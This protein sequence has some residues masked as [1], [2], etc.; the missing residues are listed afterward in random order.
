MDNDS[1]A[2]A[3]G[4]YCF[5]AGVGYKNLI[6]LTLGTGIGG[7]TIINGKLLHGQNGYAGHIGFMP[8]KAYDPNGPQR[9]RIYFEEWASGMAIQERAVEGIQSSRV[10]SLKSLSESKT[11][12]INATQVFDAAR[13]GDEFAKE[14]IKETTRVLGIGIASLIHM[15]NPDV[16]I[17]GGGVADQGEILFDPVREV[18]R[19]IAMLRYCNTPIIPAKLGNTAGV[20]GA[21]ALT[22]F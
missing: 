20:I 6:C 4:E 16:I 22:G 21:A 1:K 3:Y 18:V 13:Q 5:G 19:E 8:I 12:S 17:L 15:F 11:D 2:A 14:I 10:T 9:Q 7:G